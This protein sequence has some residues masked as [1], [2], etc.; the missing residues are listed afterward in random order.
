MNA[1]DIVTLLERLNCSRIKV[2]GT[3][4]IN[5]SCPF[6]PYT[7]LHKNRQDAHPSFGVA[8]D[9]GKSSYRCFTCNSKGTMTNLLFRLKHYAEQEQQE[10]TGLSELFTWVQDRDREVPRT[11]DTLKA[12]LKNLDYKQR[13]PSEVGGILVSEKT[14]RNVAADTVPEVFLSEAELERFSPLTQEAREYLRHKRGLSD[15]T[16]EEW[17][18]RWHG[19]SRRIAIPI[20]DCKG[21]LVGIS[22][23]SLAGESKRKF[24]HST[25]FKRDR[26]LFGENRLREGQGGRGIVVEGFFDAIYLWQQGY[27]AVALLGTSPS[28]LQAEKLV[29]FFSEIVVFPD[30]DGAGYEGAKKVVAALERRLKTSVAPVPPG[31][32]PDELSP[33]E[34]LDI[35]GEPRC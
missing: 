15:A 24:L 21:R 29:R 14:A 6:A 7:D 22:G 19:E 5:A 20:R 27:P 8:I 33:L 23:R 3:K 17:G 25:G 34:L 30:G 11:V 31:R 12:R 32:D 9:E 18:F 28:L 35:L 2:T 16:I 26:Y 1:P 4:W 13:V 10:T